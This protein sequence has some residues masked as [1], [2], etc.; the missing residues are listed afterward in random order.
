MKIFVIEEKI[1][2]SI[3]KK[4]CYVNLDTKDIYFNDDTLYNNLLDLPMEII[5]VIDNMIQEKIACILIKYKLFY[6]E[7]FSRLTNL[8]YR[9]IVYDLEIRTL[10]QL[11]SVP[12]K[13][14]LKSHRYPKL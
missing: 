7:I 5:P 6:S 13:L 9:N 10:D 2:D 14:I 3:L 4:N 11:V 12:G 1:N 8:Q